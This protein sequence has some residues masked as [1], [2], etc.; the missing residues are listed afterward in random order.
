[1]AT[2]GIR[3]NNPGNIRLGES[4]QGLA[5]TQTD[6]SFC[7]FI[8]PEYGI[9]AIEKILMAY[10]KRGLDTIR[11]IISAWAPTNE[12]DTEAYIKAVA[13]HVGIDDTAP[14]D[15]DDAEL[16]AKTIE[17]IILHENG[18]QPYS[19]ETILKGIELAGVKHA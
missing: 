6:G 1:M 2:R 17:A 7:Q 11:E 19:K 14:L 15:V 12:N 3:N 8:A 18:S 4:W 16:A 5:E 13:T 9:R 10:R